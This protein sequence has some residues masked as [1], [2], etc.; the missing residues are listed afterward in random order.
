MSKMEISKYFERVHYNGAIVPTL[1]LLNTLQKLHLLNVPFENL[2]IHY[3]VPIELNLTNIF[4]KVIN[5]RRGGFCYELNGLFYKLLRS[6]GFH[7]KMVSARVLN[8]KQQ[9]FFSTG[10]NTFINSFHKRTSLHLWA[11][12]L[13]HKSFSRKMKG[14]NGLIYLNQG[15]DRFQDIWAIAK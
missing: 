1:Q 15:F 5:K 7:V 13:V 12:R 14:N 3:K 8:N 9:I 2:D 6:I 11:S 4:E 10:E